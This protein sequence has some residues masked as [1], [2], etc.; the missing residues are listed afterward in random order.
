MGAAKNQLK[1]IKIRI[2]IIKKAANFMACFLH[3][4]QRQKHKRLRHM[5]VSLGQSSGRFL[6]KNIKQRTFIRIVSIYRPCC[7][8]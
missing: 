7:Y 8:A 6:N 4:V 1:G 2:N 3:L 5:L